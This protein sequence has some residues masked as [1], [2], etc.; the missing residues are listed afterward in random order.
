MSGGVG[1]ERIAKKGWQW[2]QLVVAVRKE[3]WFLWCPVSDAS[4]L[5]FPLL[6]TSKLSFLSGIFHASDTFD[7]S[8]GLVLVSFLANLF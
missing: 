6:F 4:F 2:D 3:K 7:N 5:Y 1:F 8:M